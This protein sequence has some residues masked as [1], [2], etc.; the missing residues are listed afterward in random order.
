[1]G[2]HLEEP[3]LSAATAGATAGTRMPAAFSPAGWQ[4]RFDQQAQWTA[5][6]RQY[7]YR[8]A[9]LSTARRILDVGCGP[10]SLLPE[11][12]LGSPAEVTGL[13]LDLGF[14]RLAADRASTCHIAAGDALRLPFTGG[15][16]DV[17]LCHFVLLW[18]RDPF[19][20]V[21]EMRRVTRPGGVVLALAEPDY[22]G[23]I[24][25]PAALAEVGRLQAEALRRQ[26]ADPTIGRQL[27]GLFHR[28]GL[29]DVQTGLLGGEWQ[30]PPSRSAWESEWATLVADLADRL[31]PDELT[32]LRSLDW[33]A[34]QAGERVLFVPTFYAIGWVAAPEKAT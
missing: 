21:A 17:T 31:P 7:L 16:F 20:A 1:M 33:D 9:A 27:S 3:A 13:D 23:R 14:L 12:A 8:R 6:I 30:S 26:G 18:L 2:R 19:Q 28:A 11:L 25:H 32:R 22:G 24:D 29:V 15:V 10:G 34:W 4:A 5:S